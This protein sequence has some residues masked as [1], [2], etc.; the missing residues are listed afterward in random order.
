MLYIRIAAALI[1]LLKDKDVTKDDL[2]H[3]AKGLGIELPD[4]PV[5]EEEK[6]ALDIVI[7]AVLGV[8]K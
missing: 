6:H 4:L 3:V 7:E 8:L 1:E 2:E 5:T